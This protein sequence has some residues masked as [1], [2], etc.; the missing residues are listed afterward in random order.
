MRAKSLEKTAKI[1]RWARVIPL[2]SLNRLYQCGQKQITVIAFRATPRTNMPMFNVA[3]STKLT[4]HLLTAKNC[5]EAKIGSGR[6]S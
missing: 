5:A 1:I 2:M 4:V 6:L 3:R